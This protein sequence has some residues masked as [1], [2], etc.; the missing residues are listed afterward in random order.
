MTPHGKR[1]AT[2]S[3]VS[4]PEGYEITERLYAIAPTEYEDMPFDAAP[5]ALG[6]AHCWTVAARQAERR[7]AERYWSDEEHERFRRAGADAAMRAKQY[8]YAAVEMLAPEDAAELRYAERLRDQADQMLLNFGPHTPRGKGGRTAPQQGESNLTVMLAAAA[9]V[10]EPWEPPADAPSSVAHK[11]DIIASR[12]ICAFGDALTVAL[13]IVETHDRTTPEG[14]LRGLAA[15]VIGKHRQA[16]KHHVHWDA[17]R[18]SWRVA[19][20]AQEPPRP[21]EIPAEI[22][23]CDGCD[24]DRIAPG[25]PDPPPR[26]PIERD[27]F[28]EALREINTSKAPQDHPLWPRANILIAYWQEGVLHH[29]MLTEPMTPGFD[30]DVA[31]ALTA[32]LRHRLPG[33]T[34]PQPTTARDRREL[35]QILN[36]LDAAIRAGL[37]DHVDTD[38]ENMAMELEEG[39]GS[40]PEARLVRGLGGEDLHAARFLER[41]MHHD[42]VRPTRDQAAAVIGTARRAGLDQHQLEEL[43]LAMRRTPESLG[44][45]PPIPDEGLAAEVDRTLNIYGYDPDATADT[46]AADGAETVRDARRGTESEGKDDSGV[47]EEGP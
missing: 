4:W 36:D 39:M 25:H 11:W 8:L 33:R 2:A 14:A 41:S 3:M 12:M 13:G 16:I 18:H 47:R 23:L 40:S 6:G 24:Y 20:L 27:E 5:E 42:R 44:I 34:E 32:T 38:V 30:P 37:H 22:H 35:R 28:G 1:D 46:L 9:N 43:A 31:A 29:Q 26:E 10:I 17:D 15:E 7:L 19:Q 45:H 21:G